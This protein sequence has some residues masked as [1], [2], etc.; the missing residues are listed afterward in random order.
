MRLNTAIGTYM[1]EK[2]LQHCKDIFVLTSDSSLKML[3]T[4]NFYFYKK[5]A[6]F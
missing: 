2:A 4:K 5:G 1:F 6:I 3:N